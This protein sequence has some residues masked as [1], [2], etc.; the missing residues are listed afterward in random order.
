M[1]TAPALA[2]WN[3]LRLL[4]FQR[5]RL[6]ESCGSATDCKKAV[7][8]AYIF[9]S[10]YWE[11]LFMKNPKYLEKVMKGVANHRRIEILTLLERMPELAL[12]EI[13]DMLEIN[14]KTAS[15]H[16][17]RLVIPGLVMKRYAGKTVRHALSA[18]G[19]NILKFLRTLE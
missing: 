7:C 16:V 8:S 14:F 10:V 1:N 13:A 17:R 19:K 5:H 15:E 6:Q 18:G 11:V 3:R 2:G 12:F 9:M 4:Y